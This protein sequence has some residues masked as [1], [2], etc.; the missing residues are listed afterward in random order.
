MFQ[1]A[2]KNSLTSYY[3]YWIIFQ[4]IKNKHF[5]PTMIF[6][7]GFTSSCVS[8]LLYLNC[9]SWSRYLKFY[10]IWKLCYCLTHQNCSFLLLLQ[11]LLHKLFSSDLNIWTWFFYFLFQY[12]NWAWEFFWRMK[13]VWHALLWETPLPVTCCVICFK[14][15]HYYFFLFSFCLEAAI[16]LL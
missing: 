2:S 3:L 14:L 1:V 16:M 10:A 7:T 12:F 8:I 15:L 4:I 5:F 11:F 6:L 13:V 9:G